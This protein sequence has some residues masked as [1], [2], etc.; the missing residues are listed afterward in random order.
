[1]ELLDISLCALFFLCQYLREHPTTKERSSFAFYTC[2][3]HS[4]PP[5]VH[6][7]TL[8]EHTTP[9]TDSSPPVHAHSLSHQAAISLPLLSSNPQPNHSPFN[10]TVFQT[11][12]DPSL[13]EALRLLCL[14]PYCN[15]FI[16]RG[17]SVT[18][19][20]FSDPSADKYPPSNFL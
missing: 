20:Y 10:L 8:Q 14:G 15:Y 11:Q 16:H 19:S 6:P 3:G 1:M 5:Q 17:R 13:K 4:L 2:S 18:N 9:S 12:L 7:H